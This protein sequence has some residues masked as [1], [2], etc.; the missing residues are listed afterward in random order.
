MRKG[1][2]TTAALA[3]ALALTGCNREEGAVAANSTRVDT[4]AAAGEIRAAEAQWNRD[5]AARNVEA[6]VAHFADDA[7]MAGPGS[8]PLNGSQAIAAA[9]RS[10]AADPAFRL[11]FAADRVEV[12]ESGDLGFSRGRF[13]LTST[14][15]RTG[16]PG[17]MRGTYLTVWRKQADGRWRAVED[18]VTPGP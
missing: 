8:E 12:A 5:Y 16:G 4:A 10:M 9:V 2:M 17:T 15:P 7:I 11:E 1:T 3:A 6:I 18:M 13:A 14:N